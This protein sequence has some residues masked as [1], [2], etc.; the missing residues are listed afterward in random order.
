LKVKGFRH[1]FQFNLCMH[2]HIN[3]INVCKAGSQ[4]YARFWVRVSFR[5][6]QTIITI[7]R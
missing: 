1:F 5:I 4:F 3:S 7:C 2:V 6:Q